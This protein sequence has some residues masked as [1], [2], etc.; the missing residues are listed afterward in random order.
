MSMTMQCGIGGVQSQL[1]AKSDLH[2]F[3][4]SEKQSLA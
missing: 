3:N 2:G 1:E 4:V